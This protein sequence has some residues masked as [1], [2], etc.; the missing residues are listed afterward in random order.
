MIAERIPQL[1]NLSP[2][3]KLILVGEIWDELA[4]SPN[5]LPPRQDH[6]DLLKQR[7]ADYK[8]NPT[9][10]RSWEEVKSAITSGK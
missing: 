8:K 5:S 2:E 7:L 6:I 3:E 4:A 1:Q 10:V 9:D